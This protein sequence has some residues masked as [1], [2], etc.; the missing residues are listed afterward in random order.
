MNR[1]FISF[2]SFVVMICLSVAMVSCGDDNDDPKD[3][4]EPGVVDELG[5]LK[6]VEATFTLSLTGDYD[7]LFST[8]TVS[9]TDFDGAVKT[10]K[11][12]GNTITITRK[13]DNITKQTNAKLSFDLLLQDNDNAGE[14][15]TYN[16]GH[17]VTL[18]VVANYEKKSGVV[19]FDNIATAK[20]NTMDYDLVAGDNELREVLRQ[21]LEAEIGAVVSVDGGTIEA[22]T[23]N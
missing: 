11:M 21:G 3:P 8:K 9:Y 16:F 5:D 17:K 1:K 14:T 13:L 23:L 12:T 15:K 2:F 10:E 7:Q 4:S 22:S 19:K 18:K 6:S 20:L